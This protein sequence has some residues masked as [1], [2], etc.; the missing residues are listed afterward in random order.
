MHVV[1]DLLARR[2]HGENVVEPAVRRVLRRT[3]GG[4]SSAL[5]GK[6]ESTLRTR[7]MQ[8]RS[9]SANRSTWPVTFAWSSQPP[10][11][12]RRDLLAR[13]RREDGRPR[14]GHHGA[15]HLD[16]DV[17]D[18]GLPGRAAIALA[19]DRRDEGDAPVPRQAVDRV[20]HAHHPRR[21]HDVR[22]ARAAAV[23][24]RDNRVALLHGVRH[25]VV[26]LLH[27]D[28]AAGACQHRGVFARD[29]DRPAVEQA[30]AADLSVRRGLLAR[31][32]QVAVRQEA[33]L[34]EAPGVEHEDRFARAR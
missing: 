10:I 16:D 22:D 2:Q 28:P 18:R 17:R 15:L 8:S 31:F 1:R 26:V 21:A 33:D 24:Q 25:R 19:E 4:S 23:S 13:R 32:G 6:Y 3:T 29:V 27:A 34:P 14:D 9:S 7:R 30:E 12:S 5:F 20:D 11:S